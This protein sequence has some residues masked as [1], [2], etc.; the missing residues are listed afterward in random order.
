VGRETLVSRKAV[1]DAM[2]YLQ[3]VANQ[4]GARGSN[5]GRSRGGKVP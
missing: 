5:A 2:V 3:A 4:L 1:F